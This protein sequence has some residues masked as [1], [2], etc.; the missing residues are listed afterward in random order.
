MERLLTISA[1]DL[2][3]HLTGPI[4]KH[5]R[6]HQLLRT[7]NVG[8]IP[9]TWTS[10]IWT[11]S[12]IQNVQ[13]D[14]QFCV[15]RECPCSSTYRLYH[16]TVTLIRSVK[17]NE[18]SCDSNCLSLSLELIKAQIYCEHPKILWPA[19]CASAHTSRSYNPKKY[20]ISLTSRFSSK[21]AYMPGRRR[22]QRG[23]GRQCT[24]QPTRRKSPQSNSRQQVPPW[25]PN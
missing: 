15:E 23:R 12:H 4:C 6:I 20:Q 25:R 21:T 5:N 7:A 11:T 8:T 2:A 18:D 16:T 14:S 3:A 1:S 9:Q 17:F 13:G 19:L 22:Q 24:P 10:T